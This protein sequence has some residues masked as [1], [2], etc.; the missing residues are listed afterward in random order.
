VQSAFL[1]D[2]SAGLSWLLRLSDSIVTYRARYMTSPEWLPVLDLVVLDA[3]NP[4]SVLFS[5]RGVLQYLETLEQSYGPCG[6]EL[7]RE[8]VDFLEGMDRGV[9]LSPDSQALRD[10]ISGLRGAALKLNDRLTQRFFN[11]GRA[12]T[13]ATQLLA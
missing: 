3:S 2:G 13:W 1:H 12:P 9:H 11:V 10:T 7:F 6:S 5:A 4:R 8:H